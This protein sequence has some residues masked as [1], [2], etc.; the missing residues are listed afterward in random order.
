MDYVDLIFCHRPDTSTPIEE[1]VRAMNFVINQVGLS[2]RFLSRGSVL[3]CYNCWMLSFGVV[4]S[5]T[6]LCRAQG[7]AHYWG[8]PSHHASL[9]AHPRSPPPEYALLHLTC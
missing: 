6:C 3:T 2:L 7:W 4:F 5:R 1:T 8:A 9:R